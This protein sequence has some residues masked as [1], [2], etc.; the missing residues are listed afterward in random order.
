MRPREPPAAHPAC[1]PG[2]RHGQRGGLLAG[3]HTNSLRG[4]SRLL[5]ILVAAGDHQGGLP[6]D[7][8]APGT[9]CKT[10]QRCQVRTE[11]RCAAC[12]NFSPQPRDTPVPHTHYRARVTHTCVSVN[13]QELQRTVL[14][15]GRSTTQASGFR[16]SD[17]AQAGPCTG[18]ST[19]T[20]RHGAPAVLSWGAA[21]RPR[22]LAWRWAFPPKTGP[23]QAHHHLGDAA[24]PGSWPPQPT[25][26]P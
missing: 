2:A 17:R 5:L 14:P 4:S 9:N 19:S 6:G 10:G 1:S 3:T 16:M 24:T 8:R 20:G 18:P 23:L 15:T 12:R 21:G 11:R 13:S 26:L 22:G 7:T 25:P